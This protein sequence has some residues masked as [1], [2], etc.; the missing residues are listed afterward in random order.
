MAPGTGEPSDSPLIEARRCRSDLSSVSMSRSIARL[1]ISFLLSFYGLA[2]RNAVRGIYPRAGD[3]EGK[4]HGPLNASTV[5]ERQPRGP[6]DNSAAINTLSRELPVGPALG[7]L[8]PPD[9]LCRQG[10][11]P[12]EGDC[13]GSSRPGA[14][15][16]RSVWLQ[17]RRSSGSNMVRCPGHVT[18][19]STAALTVR[20]KASRSAERTRQ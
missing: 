12:P 17:S 2:G 3:Q 13:R 10:Q 19:P 18:G 20:C 1:N 4:S 6:E 9:A 14:V 15:Q 7:R 5:R 8:P 16:G 11:A